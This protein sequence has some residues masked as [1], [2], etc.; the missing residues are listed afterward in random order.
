MTATNIHPIRTGSV[1]RTYETFAIRWDS[2]TVEDSFGRE[3]E[4]RGATWT[5][6]DTPEDALALTTQAT[7]GFTIWTN[8]FEVA[9]SP[10]TLPLA[11]PGLAERPL[12][13]G[14]TVGQVYWGPTAEAPAIG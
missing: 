6:F 4:M 7:R 11:N 3:V 8:R 2:Y 13:P 5:G 10:A 12:E 14:E 1:V 9:I